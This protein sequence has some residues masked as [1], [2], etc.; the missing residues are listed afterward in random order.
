VAD[1]GLLQDGRVV[2]ADRG[3]S[4]VRV[5]GADGS[6][7]MEMGE[8]QYIG[9]LTVHPPDTITVYDPGTYRFTKYLP[10]G[11]LVS[12]VGLQGEGG[13]A[14]E[15]ALGRFGEDAERLDG[16]P[17]PPSIPEVAEVLLDER[18][19]FWIKRYEAGTDSNWLT[20][21]DRR[22]GGD[23]WIVEPDGEV[24]ATIRLPDDLTPLDIGDDRILG[25]ARDDLGVE[26]IVL[27]R[28]EESGPLGRR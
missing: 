27:W 8:F 23:W 12:T 6:F 7:R 1:A 2:T 24:V 20:F 4:V 17:P 3:I 15:L 28:F 11:T 9:S 14:P 5:F 10:D 19:R 16:V 21:F 26:R 25:M 13:R 22:S 18:G